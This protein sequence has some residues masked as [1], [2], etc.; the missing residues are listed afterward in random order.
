MINYIE[1]NKKILKLMMNNKIK[2]NKKQ[3]K[4]IFGLAKILE[5]IKTLFLKNLN[6]Y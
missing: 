6:Q 1:K 5:T 3:F 4:E 2:N